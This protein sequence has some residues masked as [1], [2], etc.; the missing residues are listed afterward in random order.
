MEAWAEAFNNEVIAY[1]AKKNRI[2]GYS[3]GGRLLLH[4]V[5]QNPKLWSEAF[6]ISTHPGLSSG[7]EERLKTDEA[8]AKRFEEDEW[9]SLMADWMAQPVFKGSRAPLRIP[10]D[11]DRKELA[12]QLKNYSLARQKIALPDKVEWIVGE[13]DLKLRDLVSHARVVPEAGHRV[14]FDNPEALR[15]LCGI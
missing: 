1:G 15:Q 3:M 10:S 5:H 8:W 9:Y 14:L 11:F 2:I 7:H 6:A 12:F 4:A 13:R